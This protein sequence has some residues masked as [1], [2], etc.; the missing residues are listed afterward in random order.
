MLRAF[1]PSPKIVNW[2]IAAA[3]YFGT[4]LVVVFCH[5]FISLK[6]GRK[7]GPMAF[8]ILLL[9]PVVLPIMVSRANTERRQQLKAKQDAKACEA[10]QRFEKRN[11]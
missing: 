6:T 3:A 7:I 11:R 1:L 2:K 4:Y 8:A 5:V 10:R 9:F